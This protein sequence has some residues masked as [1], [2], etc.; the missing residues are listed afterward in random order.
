MLDPL[1]DPEQS[2]HCA[3]CGETK[4]RSDFSRRKDR[5]SGLMSWCKQCMSD[6]I[7]A[8]YQTNPKH[9]EQV[10][11]AIRRYEERNPQARRHRLG[12]RRARELAAVSIPFTKEQ[13]A[14]RWAYY[15]GKC[16]I[17]RVPATDAD[18]VKPISKGG[19]H[20][21]CNLRP[22]CD[23]CNSSKA[24]RWPFDKEKFLE[25]RLRRV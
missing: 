25:E 3:R 12:V 11:G 15:G 8:R 6:Y 21:L 19:A 9:R 24:A 7:T 14:Q 2:A 10:K 13:L 5:K 22:I 23:S 1:L 18:H 16:W 20:M 17:C 4:L